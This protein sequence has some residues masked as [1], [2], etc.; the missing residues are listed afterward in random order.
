MFY[1]LTNTKSGTKINEKQQ[2]L[3]IISMSLYLITKI[4]KHYLDV[5]GL[6]TRVNKLRKVN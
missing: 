6:I 5:C 3:H 2:D 4:N 1:N